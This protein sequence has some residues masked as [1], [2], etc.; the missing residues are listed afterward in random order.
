MFV[1]KT[2]VKYLVFS[3]FF[4]LFSLFFT[5]CSS[6]TGEDD[7]KVTFSGAVTLE[8]QSDH[9]GIT[10]RLYKP[11]DLDTALLRINQQ[12]P[13]IG[14]AI[15]QETE[16]DHRG[17][18][19]IATT[20]TNSAGFWEVKADDG[21]Y[22]IVAAKEGW[23][24]KYEYSVNDNSTDILL[25]N[26]VILE[27]EYFNNIDIEAG[28]FVEINE[29]VRIYESGSLIV[30]TPVTFVFKNNSR[31]TLNGVITLNNGLYTHIFNDISSVNNNTDIIRINSNQ[32]TTLDKL[33]F[34]DVNNGI[35]IS[36]S[37]RVVL[38]NSVFHNSRNCV[39]VFNTDSA[40]INNTLFNMCDYAATVT[41]S[42]SVFQKN[43]VTKFE[44]D[45][46]LAVS[47]NNAVIQQN[48]F[49]AG[50]NG[51]NLNPGL[52]GVAS[53]LYVT[54]NDFFDNVTHIKISGG[55]VRANYNNFLH[56]SANCVTTPIASGVFDFSFNFWNVLFDFEIEQRIL[57]SV[58]N[59]QNATVNFENFLLEKVDW[60]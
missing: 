33:I 24:W 26:I 53:D 15:S 4:F 30:N 27:G 16:F 19:P 59:N 39:E 20:I 50:N 31:V 47:A 34:F 6:S 54:E 10:V 42:N 32:E 21:E 22:N 58:D 5:A 52:S 11:V 25:K 23:G 46:Y 56:S 17:H 2:F 51:I 7:N 8:G 60:Y 36:G 9:S 35:Y 45:G 18:E 37:N 57:H 41:S 14:V 28:S 55:L 49:S 44:A 13:G 3:L 38:S 29:N 48:V 40:L 43:I 1:K 12:Y